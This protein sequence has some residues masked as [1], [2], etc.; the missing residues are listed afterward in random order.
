[1]SDPA[2][3]HTT[4]H[5]SLREY[6]T[7]I[8][9]RTWVIAQAVVLLPAAAIASVLRAGDLRVLVAG[10]LRGPGSGE[11]AVEQAAA[12]HREVVTMDVVMPGMDG[13][14]AARISLSSQPECRGHERS[15]CSRGN[16]SRAPSNARLWA[17]SSA[18]PSFPGHDHFALR[19]RMVIPTLSVLPSARGGRAWPISPSS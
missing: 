8:R 17:S 10:P 15:I 1:M 12:L 11:D 13:L 18:L 4:Q 3:L 6:L 2:G 9:R 7:P 16:E 5:S 14:E 19:R